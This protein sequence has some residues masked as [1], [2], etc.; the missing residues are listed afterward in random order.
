MRFVFRGHN[1]TNHRRK[2]CNVR[3]AI[4]AH[5]TTLSALSLLLFDEYEIENPQVLDSLKPFVLNVIKELNTKNQDK[6]TEAHSNLASAIKE[7]KV[8]EKLEEFCMVRKTKE[9][10]FKLVGLCT[11]I[12]MVQTMLCFI[13]AV[14]TCDWMLGLVSLNKFNK[15]FFALNRQHYARM[16][17][18]YLSDMDTLKSTDPDIWKHFVEGKWVVNRSTLPFC[19]LGADE[20][21]EHQNRKLKVQGGLVGI[22]LNDNARDR[23][24]LAN[25]ELTKIGS[26]MEKMLGM[27]TSER[28]I[29]HEISMK[30][31]QRQDS[32]VS[33]LKEAFQTSTNPFQW[34]GQE[35]VNIVTQRVFPMEVQ[36]SLDGITETGQQQLDTFLQQR[37]QTNNIKFWAPMK[38]SDVKTC[39]SVAKKVNVVLKEKTIA[40]K[41]DMSLISRLLIASRSRP[42]I[43]VRSCIS[44]YE[45]SPLPRSLFA[46]D[47]KMHH[48]L[49]KYKL[50]AV[51][52]ALPTET[53][54]ETEESI[55]A[56][57]VPQKV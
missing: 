52:E 29:H 50:M 19:A 18:L 31:Q 42:N 55:P 32:C 37:V 7:K 33:K 35:L 40:L 6:L 17:T 48:C 39:G 12:D 46:T 14:R 2:A 47:G 57:V 54:E 44:L 8:M 53:V 11:Y 22:T 16:I 23:F 9:P 49:A 34:K 24:F 36:I 1:E 27:S 28:K 43:D 15:Y 56:L 45:F 3:R 51:L 20:A 21:L 38:K 26:E 41:S 4:Q 30:V 25:P 13:R 5:I 10:L